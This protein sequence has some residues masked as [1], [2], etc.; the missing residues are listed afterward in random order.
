[1]ACYPVGL[2]PG[3]LRLMLTWA[4]PVGVMTTILA[5]AL[6]GD[7]P[8]GTL[9]GSVALFRLRLRRYASASS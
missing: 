3:W 1:M 7:L 9:I 4:A 2:Y 6:S 8:A 5:Q